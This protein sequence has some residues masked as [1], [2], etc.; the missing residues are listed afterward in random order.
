MAVSEEVPHGVQANPVVMDAMVRASEKHV[1]V[2]SEDILDARGFKLWAKGQP[3]S[4]GLQQKL[5]ERQLQ[6]PLEAC[7][8]AQD[9]VTMSQLRG[10]LEEFF[11]SESSLAQ[12]LQPWASE[13]LQHMPTLQLHTVAQLLLTT[14]L[15]TR[16][17][18]VSHAVTA[19][20]LMGAMALAK[21]D[22]VA[23]VREAMLA[24]LLHDIGEMYIQPEYLDSTDPL[25][26]L[27]HKHLAVHP[28]MAQML[29]TTTT[30]Y[31][32]A[33]CRA[34]G[35]HHERLDGSGYPARL[36]GAQMSELGKMLSV[37]EVTLGIAR[38][39]S[40]P[41]R[42]TSFALRVIPGEFDLGPVSFVCNMASRMQEEISQANL[43]SPA[44]D[45]LNPRQRIQ[46]KLH[47]LAQLH[48][49]LA[50]KGGTPP[51]MAIVDG[52][53]A[54][55]GRLQ[56][57]WNSLGFWGANASDLSGEVHFEL[58]M[59]DRELN[60]R[61]RE[62]QREC[63]LLAMRLPLSERGQLAPLWRELQV[64]ADAPSA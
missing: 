29:L 33:L 7:L 40:T 45:I 6:Q 54:R 26:L 12:G 64:E 47:D 2:A 21:G 61:L 17:S 50:L 56:I 11:A 60:Q 46:E 31:G 62:L 35:E 38:S 13:L 9:G 36:R 59:A 23:K 58:D 42:R 4:A 51:A 39:Q 34:I 16:M 5:L 43:S 20:A 37:V 32:P 24:G 44:V 22:A 53:T 41:M 15:V 14:A 52:A 19:S 8:A 28:R 18:F 63:L 25:D 49:D 1:I 30:D 55:L 3:I 57:A 27:G 10:Q 48:A